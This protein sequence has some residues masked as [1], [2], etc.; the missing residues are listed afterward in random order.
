MNRATVDIDG[1]VVPVRVRNRVDGRVDTRR[2]ELTPAKPLVPAPAASATVP[3]D[4]DAPL[5]APLDASLDEPLDP[6]VNRTTADPYAHLK[7]GPA[8]I[9][10]GE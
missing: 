9:T 5:V 1:Q 8:R 10:R 3:T 2:V 6:I 4:S 7:F